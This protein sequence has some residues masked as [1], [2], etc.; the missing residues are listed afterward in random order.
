[1]GEL[2]RQIFLQSRWAV[3]KVESAL[4]SFAAGQIET[5]DPAQRENEERHEGGIDLK[6]RSI[7]LQTEGDNAEFRLPDGWRGIDLN[8][9]EGITPVMVSMTRIAD[10]PAFLG[11]N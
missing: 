8:A 5:G 11:V 2:A 4:N 9:V 6:A 7:N 10:L 3:P 1:V